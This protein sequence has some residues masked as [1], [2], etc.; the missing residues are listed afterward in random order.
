V[1]L[2]MT[3]PRRPPLSFFYRVWFDRLVPA[4]GHAAG[5]L[6]GARSRAH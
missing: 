5:A 2:E 1:V 6:L 3:T 4:L